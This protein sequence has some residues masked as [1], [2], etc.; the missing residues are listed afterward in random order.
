MAS[1]LRVWWDGDLVGELD[2]GGGGAM[3]FQYDASWLG[4]A[5]A[6][7]L[8]ISLPLDDALYAAPARNWFANL[9]PEGAA[10]EAIA[11]ALGVAVDDDFGLLEHLG[12]E[13][14]GAIVISASDAPPSEDAGD[15]RPIDDDALIRWSRGEPVVPTEGSGDVRLSLAGAQHKLTARIDIGGTY[16][17]TSGGEATTHLLKFSS[18]DFAHVPAN[19]FLMLRLASRLG[20]A[21]PAATLDVGFAQP[22]LVV[23]RYDRVIDERGFVRRLH[24]EDLCQALGRSRQDKYRVLLSELDGVVRDCSVEPAADRRVLLRWQVFN[25]LCGNDD[26]HAKNVSL[27]LTDGPVLAPIYDLVC[28]AA[29]D[30]LSRNLGV[31]IGGLRVAADLRARHWLAEEEHLGLRT[32]AL[33]RLAREMLAELPDALVAATEEL[34]AVVPDSPVLKRVP[35]AIQKRSK[36]VLAGL[37]GRS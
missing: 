11:R 3:Y 24:Q 12:S 26:G 25:A 27:V 35:A 23:E 20:L 16:L 15:W 32:G 13:L 9:L 5:D 14:A 10:R 17:Q 29:I 21:V 37:E 30:R 33:G 22:V 36:R 4:R 8:S 18:R 28:T 1:R 2:R 19:E 34:A 31:P 7:S 6:R